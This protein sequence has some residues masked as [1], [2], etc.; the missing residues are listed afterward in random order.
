MITAKKND[1]GLYQN[2]SLSLIIA[3]FYIFFSLSGSTGQKSLYISIGLLILW[4]TVALLSNAEAFYNAIS[5]RQVKAFIVYL[6][7]YTFTAVFVGG[8]VYT[9]KLVGSALIMF[10]P[11]I[12]YLYY[13][14]LDPKKLK[15]ILI[16]S[17]IFFCYLVIN[18]LLFYSIHENAAR[19]LA[20]GTEKFGDLAIGGGYTLA[21]GS[22]I[23]GI[24]LIDLLFNSVIK[25][26]KYKIITI[27][28]IVLLCYL[29][30]ST[31]ST[32]TI[33]WFFIGA[34]L[35]LFL[36][37]PSFKNGLDLEKNKNNFLLNL[38]KI[39]SFLFLAVLFFISYEKI[40]LWIL[41]QTIGSSDVVSMRLR[42]IGESMAFGIQNSEYL[43]MRLEIP[44]KSLSSFLDNPLVGRGFEY[45]YAW[46]DT[47]LYLGGHSE[48]A[49][50]IGRMGILGGVPYFL[51]FLFAVKDERRFS[52][53]YI[54]VT[55]GWTFLLLGIFNPLSGFPTMFTLMFI[56]PSLSFFLFNRFKKY[57]ENANIQVK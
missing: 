7:F 55:Y 26:K 14:R 47:Y 38:F 50:A 16:V 6:F 5:T 23:L 17:L 29:V 42:D 19:Q 52:G 24:Y 27:I 8:V 12:I 21:Y 22:T 15:L 20:A 43:K 3:M 33:L 41:N 46:E 11:M 25:K 45:G 31:K 2:I 36:R 10:S 34:I 28:A 30:I 37:Y 35:S 40:G 1:K 9:L 18:S 53:N 44:L 54:P 48:W 4:V 39:I 49:D 51:I 57:Q 13:R 56:I 32:L